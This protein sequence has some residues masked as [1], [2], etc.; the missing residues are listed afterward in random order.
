M[1]ERLR[2]DLA[3]VAS[4]QD[5]GRTGWSRYGI[6]RC[7]AL[8]DYAARAANI[9]AGNADGAPLIEITALDFACTPSADVLIAVTGAPADLTVGGSPAPRWEPVLV[10][11]GAPI[12]IR[13]IRR[14]LRAYLA[15]RGS[16]EAPVVLGSCAP[17]PGLGT[18][19]HLGAGEE[20][21]L[22]HATPPVDHP[23]S[24]HP[25]FRLRP[26]VPRFGEPWTVDVTDG[27]E[28]AEFDLTP[29]FTGEYVVGTNS[30]AVGLRMSGPIPARGVSGELLSRGVPI[31]AVEV[32][33]GDEL[34]VLHR[35]R[36]V[37]AGYP[38][39]A[40]VTTTGLCT[41]GQVRPGQAVRFRRRTV[42]QAVAAHRNHREQL[43]VLRQRVSAVFGSLRIPHAG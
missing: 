28:A 43:A 16:F 26:Y 39:P 32:P 8:D 22:P 23:F 24:R 6:S 2:V 4:L 40:V 34:L 36:G 10:P 25:L 27:P 20:I 33:G 5:L 14:G 29:L 11:A 7:G 17:D 18:G 37:T 21:P 30:N 1:A 13:R 15:V 42:E 19:S 9:L 12:A 35:A 31:G 38:V 41:L 3:G